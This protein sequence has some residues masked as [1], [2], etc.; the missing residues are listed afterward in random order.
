MDKVDDT[1]SNL[2]KITKVKARQILDSRGNPTVEAEVWIHN[3]LFG[4]ASVPSGASTGEHEALELRDGDKKSYNGKSVMRAVTSVNTTIANQLIGMS[5][6]EQSRID[7]AMIDLDGTQEKRALGA[8][9]ILS[10]SLATARAAAAFN[11]KPLYAYLSEKKQYKLPVP[12]MNIINGGQHAGNGLAIQEFLIEPVGAKNFSEALQFG[13]E[14]YHTLKSILKKRYGESSINV[15]DEG[16]YAPAISNTHEALNAIVDAISE[17]GFTTTQIKIGIDAAATS[18]YNKQQQ[19]YQVDNN[20]YTNGEL[21]DYY[22]N[23]V[24][25]YPILTIEDPFYEEAFNDFGEL[26]KRI[27]HK[28]AIIGDDLYVTNPDRITQG[29]TQKATNAVLIKPNQIGSLTETLQAIRTAQ[30]AGFAHV[31]SHRSGE[32]DDNFISH[33]ATAT[34]SPFI[35]TGAPARGERV[36]KYNELLRIE[37][38]LG[39]KAQLNI[40]RQ[41]VLATPIAQ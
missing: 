29:I 38:E 36:S 19:T 41:K 20:E 9:A 37:E 11:K 18:F 5:C 23:L 14:V 15:G 27:S 21:A 17:A 7:R 12:M 4:R 31:V 24:N 32:T 22:M 40:Y 13:T 28:V 10:V 8:N 16:G 25:S 26:T 1:A 35:K 39:A 30:E 33:L 34:D 6:T 3:G 2:Q